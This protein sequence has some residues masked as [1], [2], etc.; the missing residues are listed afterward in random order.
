MRSYDE[1]LKWGVI[2]TKLWTIFR[3]IRME[4][5]LAIIP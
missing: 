1:K 4:S 2:R 3:K 5:I